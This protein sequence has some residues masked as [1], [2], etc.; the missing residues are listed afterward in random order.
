MPKREI[1]E[2]YNRLL[3]KKLSIY[4]NMESDYI[5]EETVEMIC[6]ECH[7][8][9]QDAYCYLL[10]NAL[11]LD[12]SGRADDR[13]L[14]EL[15]FHRMVHELDAAEYESDPYMLEIAIP[16]IKEKNWQT[17]SQSYAP[18]VSF[19]FDDYVYLP[20][21]RVIPQIGYFTREYVYPCVLQSGREWMLIT[22]NE[23]NTMKKPIKKA[24][25]KV[26][27]FGLGLG[28][29]AFMS[30]RKDE[31]ESVT[32]V[33]C[34]ESVIAIFERYILPQ[35][36]CKEKIKVIEADAFD[37]AE[38]K[39]AYGGYDY[40]FFDIWHDPS[41][42]VDAYKKLKKFEHLLPAAEFDYWIE[43]TMK[44]YM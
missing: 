12:V 43:D 27:T 42:G 34:D 30:A 39:M 10:A 24:H 11:Y 7:I 25:G 36:S 33:D 18:Y 35:M 44:Y 41:D 38:N 31:V 1:I 37:Y 15:Y 14:F 9:R 22:P 20:D 19:V 8:D 3:L 2:K 5:K 17:Q 21:G 26:L 29:F 23:I 40:V 13:E 4:L 6:R 32:V 28:Y 16:N